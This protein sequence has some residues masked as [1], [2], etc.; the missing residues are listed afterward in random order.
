MTTQLVVMLST[1]L[2]QCKHSAGGG[3]EGD[4]GGPESR[5]RFCLD[6]LIS[7]LDSL[8]SNYN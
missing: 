8:I 3:G 6:S 5:A 2:L 4:G 7:C 1:R